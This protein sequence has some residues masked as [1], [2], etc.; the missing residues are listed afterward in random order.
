MEKPKVD[1][2]GVSRYIQS[3][4]LG[5]GSNNH[6]PE[7]GSVLM[8]RDTLCI[9]CDGDRIFSLLRYLTVSL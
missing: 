4:L 9:F 5:F 3:E 8:A 1:I 6:F 7:E 2:L